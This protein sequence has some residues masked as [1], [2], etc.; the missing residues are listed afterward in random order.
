MASDDD[1][2]PWDM[3]PDPRWEPEVN[4]WEWKSLG[5]DDWQKS[6]KCP[7]CDHGMDVL[8]QDS[9]SFVTAPEDDVLAAL[10]EAEVGPLLTDSEKF[11]ARCDCGEAHEGRPA[12]ITKGCGQWA[13]IDPPPE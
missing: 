10:V 8:K 11:F 5:G 12:E 13:S 3:E 9:W 4:S 7:R 2:L 6:G 1:T